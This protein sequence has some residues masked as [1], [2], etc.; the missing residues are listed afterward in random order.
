MT[1]IMLIRHGV[2]QWNA[3]RRLQGQS[4][5]NL[6]PDGVHQAR[7]LAIHFPFSTVDAIYT[8]DLGR[9]KTTA[10]VIASKFNL[11]ITLMPE[12]REI[13]FGEWEGRKLEEVAKEQPLEFEKFF[14]KP[15]MLLIKGGE[16][17]AEL[18]SR[19]MA[20]LRKIVNAHQSGNQHI[21]II[22]HGAAIRVILAQI[23]EMPLR[24]IWSIQ[25]YNTAVNILRVDDGALSVELMNSTHHLMRT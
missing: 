8:S 2:T 17:F 19:T 6:A 3:E 18:Q 24:K 20:A 7:E 22:T 25:Q 11:E 15:D 23:L 21:V 10:E 14:K 13:N 4:D 5:V 16:T 12:F 9:A 1:R